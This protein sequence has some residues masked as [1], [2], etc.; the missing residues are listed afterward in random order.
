MMKTMHLTLFNNISLPYWNPL[1]NLLR[2]PVQ[3]PIVPLAP[4]VTPLLGT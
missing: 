2:P 3:E 4:V 1:A